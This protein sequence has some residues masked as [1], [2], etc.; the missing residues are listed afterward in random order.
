LRDPL[1]DETVLNKETEGAV[2]LSNMVSDR[3]H[4]EIGPPEDSPCPGAQYE[5]RQKM[6]KIDAVAG[7]RDLQLPQLD[8]LVVAL[9]W[10]SNDQHHIWGS[11]VMVAPGV[12]LT[13]GHVID[14]RCR[15]FL[16]EA[17]GQLWAI[18]VH[19]AGRVE[20]W[21]AD[22]FTHDEEG[23][24]LSLLTLVRTTAASGTPA[25]SPLKFS[26]ARM[27]ARMPCVGETISL[28]GFKAAGV[29]FERG[30]LIGLELIGSVGP[31]TDQYPHQRDSHGLPNPS[32][33]VDALTEGG[34]SGGAAFDAAGHLIGV[35][36][37]GFE[38]QSPSF[39]SL[40]W[41]ATYVPI[42]PQWPPAVMPAETTLGA[43]AKVGHCGI[44]HLE[45][46][47]TWMENGRQLVAI[48]DL[49]VGEAPNQS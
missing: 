35:I 12:A 29:S 22:S 3:Y 32:I 40:L 41:P 8:G 19:A 13:A 30:A 37:R 48:P 18:G 14:E 11:A 39:V 10:V 6:V 20:L 49:N 47:I 17:S 21:R 5:F 27:A 26:L 4:V 24:D 7:F 28:I 44:E 34:M 42:A 31:V 23:S 38:G 9:D 33:A 46:V 45:D 16:A 36:S 25:G 1:K 15:G 2:W 43:L